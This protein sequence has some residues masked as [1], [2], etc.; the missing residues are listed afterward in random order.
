MVPK[1]EIRDT[2]CRS[3]L[4]RSCTDSVLNGF[5]EVCLKIGRTLDFFFRPWDNKR[6]NTCQHIGQL[7]HEE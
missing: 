5:T 4:G 6:R 7:K 3:R 1:E 2:G